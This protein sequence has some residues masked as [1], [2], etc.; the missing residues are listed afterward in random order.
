MR[1]LAFLMILP[2]LVFWA[3]SDSPTGPTPPED[4]V[5]DPGLEIDLSKMTKLPSGLYFEDVKVGNGPVAE[6]GD[7]ITAHYTG[8]LHSGFLFDT[9]RQ[10]LFEPIQFLL[11]PSWV[12]EG[13]VE[14]LQGMREGGIRKLV[15]PSE[16]GYG[17][18]GNPYVY[19]PPYSTLVFEVEILEVGKAN[20]DDEDGE[21]DDEA[22]EDETDEEND[23]DGE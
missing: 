2:A 15:I 9:S 21:G 3:C 14:G 13:W 12:I 18:Q 17:K 22:G 16:L 7:T 19:I 6:L 4:L 11:D 10:H 1:R 8:W 20:G 23:G 5:F